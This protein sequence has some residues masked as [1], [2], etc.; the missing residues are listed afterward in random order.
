MSGKRWG[1]LIAA[2]L[3]PAIAAFAKGLYNDHKAEENRQIAAR[4]IRH[5]SEIEEP[6]R[7]IQ[8]LY[9]CLD[10]PY[11]ELEREMQKHVDANGTLDEAFLRKHIRPISSELEFKLYKA[12]LGT[13][14]DTAIDRLTKLQH[15]DYGVQ[16]KLEQMIKEDV[17]GM[18]DV[19]ME[20]KSRLTSMQYDPDDGMDLPN[21][22]ITYL[23]SMKRHTGQVFSRVLL[24]CI[25][26][27]AVERY[28]GWPE[29]GELG[30]QQQYADFKSHYNELVDKLKKNQ[31]DHREVKRFTDIQLNKMLGEFNGAADKFS[32]R[33]D[34]YR[35]VPWKELSAAYLVAYLVCAAFVR[36]SKHI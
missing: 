28:D 2:G 9:D 24:Q 5:R 19:S 4:I 34:D 1:L 6:Q 26:K 35:M 13:G 36:K 21:S 14:I 23:N 32:R 17:Q 16:P 18:I 27:T 10:E 11:R 7:Q 30:I 25:P 8:K 31:G 15:A 22:A 3:I 29:I 20:E 33:A 12:L